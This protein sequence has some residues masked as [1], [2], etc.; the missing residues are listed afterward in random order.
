MKTPTPTPRRALPGHGRRR[1]V[2]G[3]IRATMT[4]S[5]ALA[6][7][8]CDQSIP[9]I[10]EAPAPRPLAPMTLVDRSVQGE[11]G[12]FGGTWWYDAEPHSV[13][14][15][16]AFSKLSV[17]RFDDVT[18]DAIAIEQPSAL[19]PPFEG[20]T[21]RLAIA[22]I[23]AY[24]RDDPTSYVRDDGD[25][26]RAATVTGSSTAPGTSIERVHDGRLIAE[27]ADSTALWRTIPGPGSHWI[28]LAWA[29]PTTLNQLVCYWPI[30]MQSGRWIGDPS[31]HEGLRPE[32]VRLWACRD[33]S[34]TLLSATEEGPD[35]RYDRYFLKELLDGAVAPSSRLSHMDLLSDWQ[36][37][38]GPSP[39]A[40]GD[41]ETPIGSDWVIALP[42]DADTPIRLAADE[43]STML[44]RT[45]GVETVVDSSGAHDAAHTIAFGLLQSPPPGWERA[46]SEADRER[47]RVRCDRAESHAIVTTPERVFAIGVDAI[48]V[49]F[50]ACR[51]VEW[52][53]TR[54]LPALPRGVRTWSPRVSP[55]IMSGVS[56]GRGGPDHLGF[57]DAYLSLMAR[58]YLDAI[59]LF[60]SIPFL[61]VT[62]VVGSELAGVIGDVHKRER[63]RHLMARARTHGLGTYWC[64]ALP[65]AYSPSFFE[66]HPEV[67]GGNVA[68]HVVCLSTELGEA[69]VREST[70]RILETFPD[71][72]GLVVLRNEFSHTCGGRAN[73]SNCVAETTPA[74]DPNQRVFAWI[75][76]EVRAAGSA[77]DVVAFDWRAGGLPAP[78]PS[79]LPIEVDLWVRPGPIARE[80]PEN[81]V[82]V[83]R[84]EPE[85]GA[86]LESRGARRV[87]VED[88]LTHAFPMHAVPELAVPE[89]Y[90]ARWQALFD[91][92]SRDREAAPIAF[93]GGNGSGFLPTPMTDYAL[94]ELF[95][96]TGESEDEKLDRVAA[97]W[98]GLEAVPAVRRAWWTFADAFR[99]HARF[100]KYVSRH[101]LREPITTLSP[102]ITAEMWSS[103][104]LT[105]AEWDDG[106]AALD[107]A[108][109]S[110]PPNRRRVAA[111]SEGFARA[112]SLSLRSLCNAAGIRDGWD[113]GQTAGSRDEAE[114]AARQR[115]RMVEAELLNTRAYITLVH[116]RSEMRQ[117]PFYR[118]AFSL[119]VLLEKLAT[120][121]AEVAR[122]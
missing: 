112:V 79:R 78:D 70:R 72:T 90:A 110:C 101:A 68:P 24:R 28:R 12:V 3:A 13:R 6:L 98:F 83:V 4:L 14:Y 33:G 71:L 85:L 107:E 7:P 82:R 8:A 92:A 61:D 44:M 63:M 55:R 81:D 77:L 52:L 38:D 29:R 64:V 97:R 91:V 122:R 2:R 5:A 47:V 117:H 73:C 99:S 121:E 116:D 11:R 35:A 84:V 54:G 25:L 49:R 27:D 62:Q 20:Y 115:R 58:N 109:S 19:G 40:A 30:V 9:P 69:L 65:G 57:P 66:R 23:E 80:T 106:L 103:L 94:R 102:E 108:L 17:F 15:N 76:E 48:G 26:A 43:L 104:R 22:E 87:W 1:I 10:P 56:F 89:L 96:E 39:G 51:I 32:L 118:D 41:S 100:P 16:D 21:D 88:Q 120:I 111:W 42:P 93:A 67:R 113:R 50:A 45:F 95:W 46:V 60:Q 74:T 34:W 36:H 75:V 105:S 37:L 86:Q 59:Y 31:A 18:V 53:E 114:R 119:P